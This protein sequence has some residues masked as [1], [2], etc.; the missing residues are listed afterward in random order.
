MEKANKIGPTVLFTKANGEM[1]SYKEKE[2]S[3]ILMVTDIEALFIEIEPMA[4]ELT[5]MKMVKSIKDTGEMIFITEKA[6]KNLMMVQYMKDISSMAK[7]KDLES[8]IVLKISL[9]TKVNGKTMQS[10]V[11]V[12]AFGQMVD[13]MMANGRII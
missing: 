4:M 3:S 1:E 13:I 6:E 11:K 8:T 9:Y 12:S 10:K 7:D 5:N 2:F